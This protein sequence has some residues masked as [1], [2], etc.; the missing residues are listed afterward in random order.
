[1]PGIPSL[2]MEERLQLVHDLIQFLHVG[3][4]RVW[5]FPKPSSAVAE[6]VRGIITET[7]PLKY[8]ATWLIQDLVKMPPLWDRIEPYYSSLRDH[9]FE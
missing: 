5:N 1:M 3:H 8:G 4:D 7:W 9:H 6:L 2:T